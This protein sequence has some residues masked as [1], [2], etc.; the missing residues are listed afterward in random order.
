MPKTRDQKLRNPP[1]P[2]HQPKKLTEWKQFGFNP[3]PPKEG[4]I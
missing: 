1:E 3:W 4:L 2:N